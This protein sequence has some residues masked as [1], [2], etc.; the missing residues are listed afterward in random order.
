MV[1]HPRTRE[2]LKSLQGFHAYCENTRGATPA[3][4][5]EIKVMQ[6]RLS[7]IIDLLRA[8][9][10]SGPAYLLAAE[11][12]NDSSMKMKMLR[13]QIEK[14]RLAA[15]SKKSGY[16]ASSNNWRDHW[17]DKWEAKT[18]AQIQAALQ[19]KGVPAP[20]V[21]TINRGRPKP[22]SKQ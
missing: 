15:K 2:L 9:P 19:A 11:L 17:E 18:A 6:H 3:Q 21:S 4:T 5:R 1:E 8:Q 10:I 7:L 20:H 14:T 16:A 13:L 12:T 22:R